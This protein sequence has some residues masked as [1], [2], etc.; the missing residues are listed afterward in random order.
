MKLTTGTW[1]L[2]FLAIAL[3]VLGLTSVAQAQSFSGVSGVVFDPSKGVVPDVAVTLTNPAT[4]FSATVNTNSS[5]QYEFPEVPPANGYI[6]TFTKTNFRVLKLEG[7]DLGVGV[8]ETRDASLEIGETKQTVE[9]SVSGEATLNTADASIGNVITSAQVQELPSLIRTNAAVLLELQPGVQVSGSDSQFGSVT[10]SRA[11]TANITLDG[12]DVNDETIGQAFTTVNRAP[13]DSVQEVRTIVGGADS[14]YGR[15]SGAQ[16]DLVTKSGTNDLHGSLHEYNRVSAYA[17]N[18]WFNKLAGNP[19]GSLIRN[20]YGGDIGGPILK[21]KLFFFFDYEARRDTIADQEIRTVPLDA[22][23]NGQLN[24]V[25]NGPGCN[26]TATLATNP[27]CIST[28]PI[29]GAPMSNSVQG[30]DPSGI[31]GDA[32]LISYINSRYPVANFV[33]GAGDGVNTGGYLFTFPLKTIDN[34]YVGRMD[35]NLSAAHKLFARAS[36]DRDNIDDAAP[37]FPVDGEASLKLL[38]HSRSYVIGD[39][40]LI[41]PT[42]V[43]NIFFGVARSVLDFP[44]T[45][46]ASEPNAYG[47]GPLTAPLPGLSSQG[48]NVAVPEIRDVLTWTKGRH[49]LEFGTDIKLIQDKS[50]LNNSINNVTVGLG[51][52][53]LNLGPPGSSLR[54]SDAYQNQNDPGS[55]IN[56][57]SAYTFLLGHFSEASANYNY[58][59]AGNPQTLYT[60]A[61]RKYIYNEYEL[62][63]QDTWR[64]RSDLTIS[65]GLRW[66]YHAV[67]YESNGFEGISNLDEQQLFGARL[68]AAA[69]GI[70]GNDAAPLVNYS[71][72][73]PKNHAPGYYN[74]D[75]K[76]FA[77]RIGL[78]YTPSFSHGIL[79]AIFG[80]RKSAIRLGAGINYDRVLSTLSFE[81]DQQ[82]FIFSNQIT[83][84]Y[85]SGNP[86]TDLN[87]DFRFAGFNAPPPATPAPTIDRT[88]PFTPN[89]DSS[90]NPI[91][92][93]NG[94]FPSFF[95]LNRT[96][97]TPYVISMSLGIQ[98]EL[99]HGFSIE[100]DYFGKLGRRLLADGDAAQTLNFK[101][102]TSGQFLYT[103]FGAVQKQIQAGTAPGAVAPQPWFEN[104]ISQ[105]VAQ[106]GLT[107]PTTAPFFNLTAANCTQLAAQVAPFFPVGDVS[108]E[109]LVLT[110]AGIL[111]PNVGLDAQTGSAGYVGNYGSSNY[112]GLLLTVR[113]KVSAGLQF[114]FN[115]AYSHAIDNVSDITNNAN[116]YTGTG[117]FLICDLRNLRVCRSSSDFDARHTVSANFVYYLPVGTGQHF[118]GNSGKI[119]NALVGGWGTSGIVSAHTGYPFNLHTGAFPINFTQDAPPVFVGTSADV[120]HGIHLDPSTQTVQYFNDP[121]SGFNAFAFPF[122]GGTGDRNSL[123]AP[124]FWN[125]DMALLKN[126]SMPWSERQK[127]QFRAEAFNLF[128][129]PSFSPP[130]GDTIANPGTFGNITTTASTARQLQLA[131]RYDF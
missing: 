100:A 44:V 34:T 131:L 66:Q 15:S 7:I 127:L 121:T 96:L 68:S 130:S 33:S 53:L 112:N 125:V 95:Q 105:A 20:Q 4:G 63:A 72:G 60:P 9:V 32:A 59:L 114:D 128:N 56:Y 1:S 116:Q 17:A 92:L 2:R 37:Q 48:R 62:F 57:D 90:G 102:V 123:R 99:S 65:A 47:F 21:D 26:S 76:D 29:S 73:G 8:I 110:S 103:A 101:D 46:T 41:S 43:N 94:G 71:L 6:L 93:A 126:F 87:G 124:G 55:M 77:P 19:R 36:W 58:D 24:Y 117:Q 23:R 81:L 83:D 31:G 120:A 67:P 97:K 109:I 50:N 22:L 119:L 52:N 108:S 118:L 89:V 113:K 3:C 30:L 40:W 122:G 75:Y 70:S 5:G 69:M 28:L 104:Q 98:R 25:N 11:D 51:G 84:V 35:Y 38:N 79:G 74:P 10:G 61:N 78:A 49:T 39:T 18:D 13:I 14:T 111:P 45:S 85:D 27:G 86:P 64:V 16:I 42:I 115:Y 129:H 82:N 107:C 80:D 88:V 54:P 106:F 12:L 91:G